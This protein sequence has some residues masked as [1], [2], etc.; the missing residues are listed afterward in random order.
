MSNK[1]WQTGEIK[2]LAEALGKD[3]R[4]VSAVINRRISVSQYRAIAFEEASKSIGRYVPWVEWTLNKVST[5][6]AF[7]GQPIEKK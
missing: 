1:F 5:H 3:I 7:K 2:A 4:Y 6:P